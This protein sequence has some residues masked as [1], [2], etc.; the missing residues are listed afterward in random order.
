MQPDDQPILHETFA[1]IAEILGAGHDAITV[2]RAVIGLF[3]TGVKLS[4][5]IAGACATP[6]KTIPEAVCCPSSAMAMPFPGKLTGRPALD[7]AQEALGPNGIR[8]AVGIATMNALADTCWHRRPHPETELRL[9]VDAFD[10]TAIGPDDKV[11]VVGAFVPFLRELRRRRQP[12]LVLEQD[13]ATL[14]ADELPFFR[15]A[16]QADTV[17][18]EADVLLITGTT[19]INGTLEQLLALARPKARVT[20]VGPTVSLL[21]DAFLRRG[22]D[23]LG[24]VRITMPDRF[25]DTLAR[26]DRPIT[27]SAGRRR[28]WC[29]SDAPLST[30]W[31]SQAIEVGEYIRRLSR[32]SAASFGAN[33]ENR[34]GRRTA[35]HHHPPTARAVV[36]AR[37]SRAR[38]RHQFVDAATC[39][40]SRLHHR[41]QAVVP[42][43]CDT[44]HSDL[45]LGRLGNVDAGRIFYVP[46]DRRKGRRLG[47]Q[48]AQYRVLEYKLGLK[49]RF[50]N[51]ELPN[52]QTQTVDVV[53]NAQTGAEKAA[54]HAALA[55]PG[56]YD[57]VISFM[58][59]ALPVFDIADTGPADFS[60]K[61]RKNSAVFRAWSHVYRNRMS[62][63]ELYQLGEKLIDLEDAFR[64]WRFAH[65][66]TVSRVIGSNPGTGGS[67]GLR[68]LKQVANQLFEDPM[69]PELWDVRSEMFSR[70]REFDLAAAGYEEPG[71]E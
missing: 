43:Q 32:A 6:I 57:A 67:S 38:L 37:H 1:A 2:E 39:A 63:P 50:V 53:E 55:A 52:G 12:F 35:F 47:L 3:F 42:G 9:G 66:A 18:P 60:R 7:L 64:K 62:A 48:S 41:V 71:Q 11:V 27:S 30:P 15:P 23:I 68:Y 51:F 54:L 34:L 58:A 25:L 59:R 69:Y 26:A 36:Q 20:M 49:Y 16:E 14:K 21:P 17:V 61:H 13:P 56:I 28:R 22:A 29:W 24:A 10:A 65:L 4:N 44:P 5:G 33:P 46:R 70:E 45:F 19:L 8:R 40:R 31:H